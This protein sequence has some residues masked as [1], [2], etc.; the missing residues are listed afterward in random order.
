MVRDSVNHTLW[1]SPDTEVTI[2]SAIGMKAAGANSLDKSRTVDTGSA[3]VT[4]NLSDNH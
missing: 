3:T 1:Q 4:C 2:I